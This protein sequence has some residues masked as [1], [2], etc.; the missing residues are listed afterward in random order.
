MVVC[1]MPDKRSV[2]LQALI[3]RIQQ[4]VAESLNGRSGES[5]NLR[6]PKDHNGG[7]RPHDSN[8]MSEWT[9][10]C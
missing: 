1:A 5:T 3:E 7:K 8:A 9:D 10:V 4:Y 6:I 2:E